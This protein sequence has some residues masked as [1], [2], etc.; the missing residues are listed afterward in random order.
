MKYVDK[1][2]MQNEKILKTGK[3]H[4]IIFFKGTIPFLFGI[5]LFVTSYTKLND[6]KINQSE[7]IILFILTILSFIIGFVG[8]I[9]LIK[10]TLYFLCTELALTN[11]RVI[12]KFGFIR[13][14]TMELKY[15]QVEGFNL[16]QSIFGRIFN[17]GSVFIKGTGGGSAPNRLIQ[18]I[19]NPLEFKNK[20][21]E[22]VG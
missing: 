10:D 4:W 12:A 17:Y 18:F 5:G 8:L 16:K 1:S 19:R 21:V 9:R 14:D 7:A 3:I 15:N 6:P 20:A 2:L 22:L 11:R 13:R